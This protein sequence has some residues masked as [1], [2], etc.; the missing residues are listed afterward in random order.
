MRC[1]AAGLFSIL[2]AQHKVDGCAAQ[3]RKR[4]HRKDSD[5]TDCI[6]VTIWVQAQ[7]EL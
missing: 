1:G 7:K 5:N 3:E 2:Y 4:Q 6:S